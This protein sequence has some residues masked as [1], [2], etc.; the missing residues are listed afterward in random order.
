MT[1]RNDLK[2]GMKQVRDAVD[3]VMREATEG[4]QDGSH[5]NVAR[6]TNIKV[7]K[8]VGHNG[9]TVHASATQDA[10]IVQDGSGASEEG[11]PN[12]HPSE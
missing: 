4:S 8:N 12:G 7:A 1:A 10:P 2:R 11:T 3:R 5:I 6:R 9:G